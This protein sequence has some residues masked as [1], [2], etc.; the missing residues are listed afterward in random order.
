MRRVLDIVARRRPPTAVIRHGVG[1]RWSFAGTR[2][3]PEAGFTLTR[4]IAGVSATVLT[5]FRL[6]GAV[7]GPGGWVIDRAALAN[8]LA[9]RSLVA[10]GP[11]MPTPRDATDLLP[12]L[13]FALPNADPAIIEATL[14]DAARRMGESHLTDAALKLHFWKGLRPPD[15]ATLRAMRFGTSDEV[16]TYEAVVSHYVMQAT[17]FLLLRAV[18]F[19]MAR[20]LGLGLEDIM[21]AGSAPPILYTVEA[22][23]QWTKPESMTTSVSDTK[24]R[25]LPPVN[26]Q[27]RQGATRIGYPPFA[28]FFGAAAV[29]S[30]VLPAAVG[31]PLRDL[32]DLAKPGIRTYRAPTARLTWDTQSEPLNGDQTPLLSLDA[33]FW[34]IER[35][36]F[37]PASAMDDAQPAVDVTTVFQTCHDGDYVLRTSLAAF[38]DDVDLPWGDEPLEGWFAYR[39]R[40]IDLLGMMGPPSVPA[41]V[42][43]RDVDA[44]P[45]PLPGTDV[46]RVLLP[47][48][49]TFVLP[50]SLRWDAVNEFQAPDAVEFRIYQ[51][52]TPVA[53]LPLDVV[54]I[55]PLRNST[56]AAERAL[57]A[58]QVDIRVLDGDG[59]VIP[60]ATR[61]K[62]VQGT[63][64]TADAE[65][66]VVGADSGRS[67][68]RVRKSAGRSPAMRSATVRYSGISGRASR[69]VHVSR[70]P[71][72]TG[73]ARTL[74]GNPL[75]LEVLDPVS[76]ASLG[77]AAGM[78]RLQL[79]GHSFDCAPSSNPL[80]F[81]VTAPDGDRWAA[82]LLAALQNLAPADLAAFLDGSPVVFL[83]PQSAAVPL[84]PPLDYPGGALRI[85]VTTADDAIYV[86]SAGGKGNEGASEEL[87]LPAIAALRPVPVAGWVP[88]LWARDAAEFV[89][90]AEATFHWEGMKG[91]VR[92]DVERALE[93]GLGVSPSGSDDVLIKAAAN[94]AYEDAFERVTSGAFLP[95]WKDMLPGRAPT[96]AIYRVRGVSASNLEGPW[97]IIALVRVPDSRIAP[98][99]VLLDAV[100]GERSLTVSW[101]QPGPH[102][103]IG[104]EI[105]TR[106]VQKA[107][108]PDEGW[109]VRS[110]LLPGAILPD[111]AGRFAASV[112]D[113]TPGRALEV[114]VVP[115]RHALDPDD[116][117]AV[118][119]RRIHGRPSN[120]LQSRPS[121]EI[122]PPEN[123]TAVLNSHG[124]VTLA[125]QNSDDYSSIEVRRRSPGRYGFERFPLEGSAEAYR[126]PTQ[127]DQTGTWTYEIAAAGYGRRVVSERVSVEWIVP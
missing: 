123:V 93:H 100:P 86:S 108:D 85:S 33:Y 51:D 61:A 31:Q 72:V 14:E 97:G 27:A 56:D 11:A 96:R 21:P 113:C 92:Y 30:P 60:H 121:G 50:L 8:D 87:L 102:D 115:A 62:L 55:L 124:L 2:R 16:A 29:W 23:W 75:E 49:G 41:F 90:V 73:V 59:V 76:G 104:F 22:R 81:T 13:S 103:G 68:L 19:G 83:P 52:W 25:P 34:R 70:A 63:L 106:P 12:V 48:A 45:P 112:L 122:L 40:G 65:F 1:V 125:W 67:L 69:I 95:R 44:P 120:V 127:L 107:A 117:R 42:R 119:L 18:D 77:P 91:A 111:D 37:G 88:R 38:E 28:P 64:V 89:D 4:S 105:Q 98:R 53:F 78:M 71:A 74:G 9:T 116:P 43:L 79:L 7:Q 118:R 26:V 99:A 24:D 46:E 114:R 6:P 20:F 54:E 36:G 82:N 109:T 58:V 84:D 15:Y 47:A 10:N 32:L 126:E 35:H 57:D 3:F 17:E 66:L 101:T 80:H 94:P 110:D 5:D 39:I